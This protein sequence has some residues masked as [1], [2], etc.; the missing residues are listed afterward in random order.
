MCIRDRVKVRSPKVPGRIRVLSGALL[1]HVER[2]ED[3]QDG[4]FVWEFSRALRAVFAN[5]DHWAVLSKRAVLAFGSRYSLRLYE[6]VAL[7][8]G[9]DHKTSEMFDLEDLRS[10]LGV[11]VGKMKAWADLRRFVLEPAIAE[12]NQLSGLKVAYEVVK[13][14]RAVT[15]I[16]LSW[17]QKEGRERAATK[18]ELDGSSVG[19]RARREQTVEQIVADTTAALRAPGQHVF[20]E[21]GAIAFGRWAALVRDH[22]RGTTP[23]VNMVGAEFAKWCRAKNIPLDSANIEVTFVGFCKQ[24]K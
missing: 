20:P 3:D 2:D 19:R 22:V 13:R 5:S 6:I 14:R 24:Y 23:D 21:N 9:L 4:E 8:V 16:T 10:R 12:V 15:A 11:P 1:S 7:R 17:A 18:R